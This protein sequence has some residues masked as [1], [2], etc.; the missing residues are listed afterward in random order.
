MALVYLRGCMGQIRPINGMIYWL[1]LAID[2]GMERGGLVHTPGV[3]T[4]YFDCISMEKRL[5]VLYTNRLIF[6][7][8]PNIKQKEHRV[9][10]SSNVEL[11][12]FAKPI[13]WPYLLFASSSRPCLVSQTTWFES[14]YLSSRCPY[15]FI[16]SLL[17]LFVFIFSISSV[18][19]LQ[20]RAGPDSAI[21]QGYFQLGTGIR[22][23]PFISRPMLSYPQAGAYPEIILHPVAQFI[24]CYV[25]LHGYAGFT[26]WVLI[27]KS[28]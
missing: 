13:R 15:G 16:F 11:S 26:A 14:R 25:I 6:T 18:L 17:V 22:K 4:F 24:S 23:C 9:C 2:W 19:Y 3:F 27:R 7:A 8:F 10:I 12:G 5:A 21:W 28:L 1:A 20:S